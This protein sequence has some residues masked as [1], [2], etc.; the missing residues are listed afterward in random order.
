MSQAKVFVYRYL[1]SDDEEDEDH[2]LTG[3]MELPK[4][5]DIVYRKG[6]I[7]KVAGVYSFP[8]NES[9]PHFR[10]HLVDMSRRECVN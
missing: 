7:W 3:E 1:E 5:G 6:K 4:R 10:V 8:L 9:I 2:D